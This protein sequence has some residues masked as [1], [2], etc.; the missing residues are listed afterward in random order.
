MI[1]PLIIH[2]ILG[3]LLLLI[4]AGV[5]YLWD[6]KQLTTFGIGIVRM[7]VQ[8]LVLCLMFVGLFSLNNI[9]HAPR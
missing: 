6:K 8:L 5:L 2:T 4:P 1:G 9:S 7:I 3:L